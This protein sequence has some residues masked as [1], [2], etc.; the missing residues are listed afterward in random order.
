M[1][2]IETYPLGVYQANCYVVSQDDQVLIIDPGSKSDYLISKI[3]ESAK[4]LAVL[5]THGHFDHFAAAADLAKHYDVDIYIHT[6]DE[7]LLS[8]PLKNYSDH[9]N[10]TCVDR[11]T[12]FDDHYLKIGPF[13]INVFHT[14]GHS[15]GSV[16]YMIDSHLFVG[17]LLFKNSIGRTDLYKGSNFQMMESLQFICS[18]DGDIKVYPGHGPLTKLVL[19][20]AQNP[21]ILS[22]KRNHR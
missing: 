8:D 9:R 15:P 21:Y 7:E 11:V 20:K 19:E 1:M 2:K 14:P 13:K 3:P 17:D 12:A 6:E 5:L 16:C 22:L 18:L 4:V 10:V